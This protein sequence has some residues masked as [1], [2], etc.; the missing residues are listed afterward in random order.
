MSKILDIWFTGISGSQSTNAGLSEGASGLFG[1]Q[2]LGTKSA[3]ELQGLRIGQGCTMLLW[4]MEGML[5]T[6]C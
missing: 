1:L 2:T 6:L 5:H 3:L 4:K